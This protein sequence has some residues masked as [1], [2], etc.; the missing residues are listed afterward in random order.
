MEGHEFTS[1]SHVTVIAEE[2]SALGAVHAMAGGRDL[3][4]SPRQWREY[5]AHDPLKCNTCI[6]TKLA[7]TLVGGAVYTTARGKLVRLV[8]VGSVVTYDWI[9]PQRNDREHTPI[10][11]FCKVFTYS[12]M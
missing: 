2:I 7:Q 6:D 1:N 11:A 10:Q 3:Y 4:Y 5:F 8:H 9:K 12:H